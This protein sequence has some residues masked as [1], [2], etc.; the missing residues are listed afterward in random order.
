[1]V[2]LALLL[3]EKVESSAVD[4]RLAVGL[5]GGTKIS[6]KRNVSSAPA[7][8]TDPVG[9]TAMWRTRLVCPSKSLIFDILGYFH[10]LN[11]FRA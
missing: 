6:Q 10:K 11:W 1:M 7:E 9:P 3:P 8:R 5:V 2:Q 4:D